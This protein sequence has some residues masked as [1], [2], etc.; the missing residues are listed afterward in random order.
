LFGFQLPLDVGQEQFDQG[1]GV[2]PV[3]F[4]LRVGNLEQEWALLLWSVLHYLVPSHCRFLP[5]PE[6]FFQRVA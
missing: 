2:A 3:Q 6:Q 1:T 5:P 4:D